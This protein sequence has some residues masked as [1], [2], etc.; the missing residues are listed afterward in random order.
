MTTDKPRAKSNNGPTT[1]QQSETHVALKHKIPQLTETPELSYTKNRNFPTVTPGAKPASTRNPP[2]N[3]KRKQQL[4]AASIDIDIS[5]ILP[6]YRQA[7]ARECTRSRDATELGYE[8]ARASYR[9]CCCC[10]VCLREARVREREEERERERDR[11][12]RLCGRL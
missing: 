3:A 2:K 6:V 10:C 11:C 8:I 7:R 5:P 1:H 12:L 9:L 4:E